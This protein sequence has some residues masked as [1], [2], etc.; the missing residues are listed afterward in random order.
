MSTF[1]HHFGHPHTAAL[2]SRE[3]DPEDED[4]RVYLSIDGTTAAAARLD[5]GE[6]RDLEWL[7]PPAWLSH[8]AALDLV[9]DLRVADEGASVEVCE[10]PASRAVALRSAGVEV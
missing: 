1:R 6:V 4:D 8:A 7:T 5:D 10:P 9:E 2:S 3:S